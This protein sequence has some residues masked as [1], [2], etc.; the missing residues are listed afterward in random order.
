[1][2]AVAALALVG[3]LV[4]GS[5]A[6]GQT[7]APRPCCSQCERCVS[8]ACQDPPAKTPLKPELSGPL[9]IPAPFHVLHRLKPAR[10][11]AGLHPTFAALLPGFDRPMRS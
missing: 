7:P 1:M 10:L 11:D 3:F 9:A 6:S 5:W 8:S 2:E 4:L